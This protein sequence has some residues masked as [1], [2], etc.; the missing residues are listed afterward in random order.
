MN[1]AG[2]VLWLELVVEL[3]PVEL[4]LMLDGG[5]HDD[6]KANSLPQVRDSHKTYYGIFLDVGFSQ[7]LPA[8]MRMI[9]DKRRQSFWALGTTS[10]RDKTHQ[11]VGRLDR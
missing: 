6:S 11:I 7:P 2:S 1:R 10:S 5:E 4:V 8:A 9:L 3:A